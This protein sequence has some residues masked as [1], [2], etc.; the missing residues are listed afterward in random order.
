MLTRAIKKAIAHAR[1][2]PRA[3]ALVW[4]ASPA[5]TLATISLLVIQGVLPAL[6]V[7][8]S[9]D[10]IDAVV[11]LLR[12]GVTD[13]VAQESWRSAF[14]LSASMAAL[15]LGIEIS[16]AA[17]DWVR[18]AHGRYVAAAVSDLIHAQSIC[19]DLAF[20]DSADHFDRLH[21]ARDDAQYRP[22]LLIENLGS[23]VQH[24]ITLIALSVLLLPYGLMLSV[25]LVVSTLPALLLVLWYAAGQHR[26]H[27]SITTRERS[28]WYATWLMTSNEPA[29][30]IR[31]L[32]LGPQLRRAFMRIRSAVNHQYIGLE[33][34]KALGDMLAS[35]C[36]VAVAGLC[37][38]WMLSRVSRGSATLGDVA[39]FYQAFSQGQKLMRT[40][41]SNLGQTYQ[42]VLF[43][44]NLFEYL[45][46][47]PAI[48]TTTPVSTEAQHVSDSVLPHT[49]ESS[50][51]TALSVRFEN[52]FFRYQGS[53]RNSLNGLSMDIPAGQIVAVVG[54]N[55]AGK[56]TLLKLLC[57]L[58]D[59]QGGRV[60]V[61]DRDVRDWPLEKLRESMSVLMQS[62]TQFNAT[63][64]ENVAVGALQT[65]QGAAAYGATSAGRPESTILDA[66]IADGQL[67]AAIAAAGATALVSRLPDGTNTMLGRWF[68]GGVNLSGGETQRIALARAFVRPAPIL[69]LDEPTS[70]MDPW[71]DA[72]WMQRFRAL[73]AGRTVLLITHRL[74]T[75]RQAHCIYVM[76]HGK[77]V[78]AGSHDALL[79]QGGAYAQSWRH[80]YG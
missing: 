2:V 71:A 70:A 46:L 76:Q 22:L 10:V 3:F 24:G 43:L 60:M 80:Q 49:V 38:L 5:L 44:G 56:S 48:R 78:E 79:E 18:A 9:K 58:Y 72:D 41:L 31:I 4:S 6:V 36:A 17:Y 32:G 21:R 11:A 28:S 39:L 61:D 66:A 8:L 77:V 26:L 37:L 13:V 33:T 40:L 16:R 35:G 23:L 62:P 7:W 42:N 69:I 30:E 12:S 59:V 54:T 75:A 65:A 53:D 1:L 68:A 57:R 63:V 14:A 27:R 64:A 67:A 29:A 50:Q 19:L 15:L 55:G 73:A 47:K 52:V 20:Y 34:R 25:A 74:A 51:P 45:D